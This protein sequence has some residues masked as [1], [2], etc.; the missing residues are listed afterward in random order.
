MSR[1]HRD[2]DIDAFDA[3]KD[4]TAA[5]FQKSPNKKQSEQTVAK[6]DAQDEEALASLRRRMA[7]PSS[8]KAGLATDQ[9]EINRKIY[10]ASKGSKYF[11]NEKRSDERTTRQ[12]N[13]LL[14]K[15]DAIMKNYPEGG[16]AWIAAEKRVDEQIMELETQR[17][18]S[19]I[20]LHADM[21]MFYAAVE[22]K[23]DPSL[24]GKAFG[25]GSGVLVTASYE[26][27]Q[28]GCRSGMATHV[29]QALCPH[30]IVV[31]NNMSSYVEASQVVMAIF[32]TYDPHYAQMS[33][34]EAY[35]DITPYCEMND[36]T[37]DAVVTELRERVQKETGL[38]VSVGIAPNKM[39]AK[40]S[41]DRNKPNGQFRVEPSHNF[42]VDLMHDLPC[43]KIPGIGRVTERILAS[44]G[45]LTCGDVAKS[46]VMLSL[47]LPDIEFLLKA[48]LGIHSNVVE[49]SKRGERKSVGREHTFRPTKDVAELKEFLRQS[50]EQVAKDLERLDYRG[51]TITLTCKLDTFQRFTRAKTVTSY[52]YK[53]EDLFAVVSK[54]L[55]IE[56]EQRNGPVSMRLI[57]VRI[58]G[59]KD[60]REPEGGGIKRLFEKSKSSSEHSNKKPR[61]DE[62]E[63]KDEDV[64]EQ[65]M[66]K[67]L[68]ESSQEYKEQSAIANDT[69]EDKKE[70]K[71]DL[72]EMECPVC[73]EM[74]PYP[75]DQEVSEV[76]LN[77]FLNQHIDICL[78]K[79]E[80][81]GNKPEPQAVP[82]NQ[83]A[84]TK[85]TNIPVN[86][87]K[88]AK[89][90]NTSTIDAFFHR[91]A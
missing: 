61:H 46:R 22:L 39:L 41:S 43:R 84:N 9:D 21:D 87:H 25:V 76:R 14:A 40:I 45:V 35:L 5:K 60:L 77:A 62:E 32:E 4:I 29:A 26:A 80:V 88:K 79:F 24:K 52:L 16:D 15:R 38:T 91:N 74:I 68:V 49:P 86:K 30:L 11:E 54:L 69:F 37:A 56:I 81:G 17:D 89:K 34:D 13:D 90:T 2:R 63:A 48:Y 72:V 36:T 10:E 27:R 71:K 66:K 28:F 47:T 33:L 53:A 64:F 55:D 8:A 51:K 42:I 75:R 44:L 12:V 85:K 59:L 78:N 58:T 1:F 73:Q 3:T 70:E 83:P 50:A 23:R 67:A 19:R 65:A 7:G 20:I 82:S 57:G 31:K 18:L 6:N